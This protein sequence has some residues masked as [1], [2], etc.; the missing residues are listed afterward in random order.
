M[1]HQQDSGSSPGA[2]LV[3]AGL[4]GTED[5]QVAASD[6]SPGSMHGASS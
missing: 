5:A 1:G 6:K 2:Q 3:I 4:S